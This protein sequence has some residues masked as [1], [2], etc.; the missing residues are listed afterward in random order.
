MQAGQAFCTACGH[1]LEGSGRPAATTTTPPPEVTPVPTPD[2]DAGERRHATVVFSDLSGYT[3][4]NESIDPEVVEAIMGRIKREATAIIEGHGGTVNQFVGDE[5]MALFGVPIARRDDPRRAIRAALAVHAAVDVI[6]AGAQAK[7][8]RVV[9]MHTGV[10]TGLVIT[11]QGD[12]RSGGFNLTG[13]TVNTAA[14][15]RA[16]AQPGEI[17]VGTETWAQVSAFFD[18]EPGAPILVKGKEVPVTPYRI[19]S[20]GTIAATA[21]RPLVGRAEELHQFEL[22]MEACL[23]R[24]KR[25]VIFV[26]GDPG[27]G[28]SRLTLE[29]L[30]RARSSGFACHSAS[31]LDFGT[32]VGRDMVRS[33]VQSL[34]GLPANADESARR[35]A[36]TRRAA[37]THMAQDRA[38]FLYDLIDVPPPPELRPLLAAISSAA[39]EKGTLQALCDL[40]QQVSAL[41]PLVL[42]VEDIHWADG[43][44]LERLAALVALAAAHPLL[45]LMTTRFAGDPTVGSWRMELHG[46]PITSI[47]LG[48]LSAEDAMRLAGNVVS[49]SDTLLRGFVERAEGNPLFLEQLMLNSGQAG[50]AELPGSI[51]ALVHARM[52]RLDSSDKSA[53][54]AAAVLGQRYTL[55]ALRHLIEDPAYD[56]SRLVEQFLVRRHGSEY[57]FCHALIRDGAY[58]T[59]LHS[60]LRR[61][62]GRAA[63]WFEAKDV[64]RCAEHFE[65]AGDPR[66]SAAYLSASKAAAKQFRYQSALTL[67][68]RGQALASDSGERFALL[69]AGA[70]W[71][72]ELGR[73]RDAILAC[74]AALALASTSAERAQALIESAASMRIIDRIDEGLAALDQ[75]EPLARESALGLELSQLHHLRGNLLF[76]LGR[77]EE[78]LHEHQQAFVR[79]QEVQSLEAQAVALGGLG[80]ANYLRGHMRSAHQQFQRCI[81]LSREQGYGRLEVTVLSMVGWSGMHL[82]QLRAA[83]EVGLQAVD[84]AARASHPRAEIIARNLVAHV[85]GWK[86]GNVEHGLRQLDAVLVLAEALGAKRFEAQHWTLRAMLELRRG[87]RAHAR[88]HV[89]KALVICKEHGMGFIGPSAY[90]VLALL[91]SDADARHRALADGEAQLAKASVGHNHIS[92]RE[93]GIDAC[94]QAGE[95]QAAEDNCS[96]LERFTSAEPL[97]LSD[98]LIARGRALA[99]FG[100]GERDAPLLAG[101]LKLR[102]EAVACELNVALPALEKAIG[103]LQ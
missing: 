99:R 30:R 9:R 75:A 26:R 47:D 12:Q 49:R 100:R 4:L 15:L 86:R 87:E 33:L 27:L 97:P 62:H 67:A 45:F 37:D 65:R 89:D 77:L 96:N 24:A 95:W 93:Y 51:Q 83:C 3:A 76:P 68:E 103:A 32:E 48:P 101:L 13:D 16:L 63:E 91:E 5:I 23:Q 92:L 25:R 73:A 58:A 78:C 85:D 50:N 66:A 52:D 35:E 79:A 31:V 21:H 2:T 11:R 88:H 64:S 42:L 29:M 56:S 84:L 20:E 72:I 43:W 1:A 46:A 38:L 98:F 36:V 71:L 94:L 70:R 53:M 90:G 39:R 81:A 17:L 44:A 40:V 61:L 55:D 10:N 80:D 22:L 102:D 54:Q 34:L 7:I 60:R 59:L 82:N 69:M 6:A 57:Q 41:A 28:K 8:G 18:A 74:N 19:R 14:R